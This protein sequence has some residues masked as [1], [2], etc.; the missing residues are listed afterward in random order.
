MYSRTKFQNVDMAICQCVY[1]E[2][3]YWSYVFTATSDGTQAK[4]FCWSIQ[5][6]CREKERKEKTTAKLFTLH[7]SLT[8]MEIA[9]LFALH[10][11]A[12]AK[13]ILNKSLRFWVWMNNFMLVSKFPIRSLDHTIQNC[14]TVTFLEKQTLK[15]W[16]F[17]Q[18]KIFLVGLLS[19][20]TFL[21]TSLC[22]TWT[23]EQRTVFTYSL[24][25]RSGKFRMNAKFHRTL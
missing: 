21:P 3:R 14:A 5:K 19:T 7:I 8:R 23:F 25:H 20:W 11:T 24:R 1:E 15:R 10:A 22:A 13:Y 2:V 17:Q 16:P 9:K 18:G 6:G 4:S 12:M